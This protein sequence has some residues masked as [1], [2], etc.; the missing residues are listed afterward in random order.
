M[1]KEVLIHH[2]TRE[3]NSLKQLITSKEI[4][5]LRPELFNPSTIYNC[6]YGLLTGDCESI[7]TCYLMKHSATMQIY[8]SSPTEHIP[9]LKYIENN[10]RLYPARKYV[11]TTWRTKGKKLTRSYQYLSPL[12][13]YIRVKGAQIENIILFLRDTTDEVQLTLCKTY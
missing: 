8:V 3:L 5:R 10:P 1:R 11:G 13:F 6:I 12:E 2:V 9:G 4:E 7:R